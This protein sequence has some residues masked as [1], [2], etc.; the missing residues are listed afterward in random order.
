MK[1][2]EAIKVKEGSEPDVKK[3]GEHE[4]KEGTE[5]LDVPESKKGFLSKL[6]IRNKG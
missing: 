4:D 6:G 3:S 2:Q 5:K 1:K